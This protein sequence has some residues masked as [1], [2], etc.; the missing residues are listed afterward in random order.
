[1]QNQSGIFVRPNLKGF[2]IG[3]LFVLMFHFLMQQIEGTTAEV[4]RPEVP[5]TVQKWNSGD[6][7]AMIE[8]VTEQPSAEGYSQIGA[9]FELQKDYKKAMMFIRKAEAF[10]QLNE[11]YE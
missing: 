4:P 1:M 6:V 2:L 8:H 5:A 11:D 3:G 10:S 7:L 9:Y